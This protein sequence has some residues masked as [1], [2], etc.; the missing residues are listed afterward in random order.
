[1]KKSTASELSDAFRSSDLRVPTYIATR[2]VAPALH[3]DMYLFVFD[4]SPIIAGIVC[5]MEQLAGVKFYELG[6]AP[7]GAIQD[8]LRSLIAALLKSGVRDVTLTAKPQSRLR[9]AAE[10]VGFELL[11]GDKRMDMMYLA[12]V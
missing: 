1:M 5:R 10:Q 8:S 4:E 12:L 6:I 9:K 2:V 7:A 3:E 11:E